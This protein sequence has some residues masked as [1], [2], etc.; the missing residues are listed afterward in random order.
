MSNQCFNCENTDELLKCCEC[1]DHCCNDCNEEENC[2]IKCSICDK[3]TCEDCGGA[4]YCDNHC[5]KNDELTYI[6]REHTST[7]EHT[8]RTYCPKEKCQK[9]YQT[10]M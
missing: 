6:C 8:D 5:G 4:T 3:V 1:E 10:V 9:M 7:D 2:F